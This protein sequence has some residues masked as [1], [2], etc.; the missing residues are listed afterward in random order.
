MQNVY[1]Y[2]LKEVLMQSVYDMYIL[3]KEV[4]MQRYVYKN[5]VHFK[6]S[7]CKVY[8]ICTFFKRSSY[9]MYI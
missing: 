8:M 3:I 5:H 6:R 7:L 2:S 1:T 4:L 9:A